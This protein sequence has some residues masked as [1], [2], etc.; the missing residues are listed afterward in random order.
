MAYNQVNPGATEVSALS[1]WIYVGFDTSNSLSLNTG[2][3]DGS[4]SFPRL[5]TELYLRNASLNPILPSPAEAL[6]SMMVCSTLD[7][8]GNVSF[9]LHWNYIGPYLEK[10]ITENFKASVKIAQYMSGG[11]HPY[12]KGFIV[13]LASVFVIKLALLCYFVFLRLHLLI[14]LCEPL[15]LFLIGHQSIPDRLFDGVSEGGVQDADLKKIWAVREKDGQL[16]IVRM[17]DVEDQVE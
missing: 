17:G 11:N 10:P 2:I 9:G 3:V 13:V 6:L 7:L 15:V 4:N 1:D 14:D 16:T 12:Q 8:V 5:L